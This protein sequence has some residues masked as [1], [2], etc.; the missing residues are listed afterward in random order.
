MCRCGCVCVF[1][2]VCVCGQLREKESQHTV[3]KKKAQR[4]CSCPSTLIDP[5]SNAASCVCVCVLRNVR[6]SICND[7]GC[8]KGFVSRG[9][10]CGLSSETLCVCV[11]VCES[12]SVCV[13]LRV[14][15]GH[16]ERGCKRLQTCFEQ[17]T[18]ALARP[19]YWMML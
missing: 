6:C 19:A 9:A 1:V 10:C 8:T 7:P 11:C 15:H 14:M 13:C 4:H 3:V 18:Q 12:L 2:F 17:C 5:Y 16:S